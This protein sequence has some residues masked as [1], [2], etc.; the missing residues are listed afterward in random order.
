MNNK[1]ILTLVAAAK[2]LGFKVN[3]DETL[4]C[5]VPQLAQF[6]VNIAA[7]TSEQFADLLIGA[8][9]SQ[10]PKPDQQ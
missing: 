5:T 7:A 2:Q 4:T 1:E 10:H 3:D 8:L 9:N 6:S